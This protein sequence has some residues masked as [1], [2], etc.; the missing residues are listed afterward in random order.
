MA[1][2]IVSPFDIAQI[3]EIAIPRL[4]VVNFMPPE[5]EDFEFHAYV[6]IPAQGAS[7][8]VVQFLVPEGRNGIIKRIANVFVGGGFQEGQ[9]NVIW[10]LFQDF[11]GGGGPVVPNFENIVASLG[12][13]AAPSTIDGIRVKESQ[14]V[15]LQVTNVGIVPAG[16]LIGGR[17][18]GYFYPKD[19]DP[20]NMG[21]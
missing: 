9:G 11:Q 1:G 15:T 21:F 2:S 19:L 16:Q 4:P 6:A 10:K 13:V 3:P 17:L 18:G 20:P 14:L 5:G 8:V 7:G 12:S